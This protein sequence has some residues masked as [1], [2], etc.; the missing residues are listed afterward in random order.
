MDKPLKGPNPPFPVII[1]A[2]VGS[3]LHGISIGNDDRDE[4]GVCVEPPEYVIGQHIF[5]QYEYRSARERTGIRDAKSEKGDLDLVVYS[6]RKYLRL[7]CKGNPS[8]LLLLFVP[9]EKLTVQTSLGRELQELAPY[10]VSKRAGQH[11]LGYL[12]AQKQR[13]LRER[14]A[15]KVPN[16]QDGGK[17]YLAHILRLG[18][19]GVEFLS[20]GSMTLPMREEEREFVVAVRRGEVDSNEALT[21]AGLLEKEISDLLTESPIADEPD[22]ET[23]N[24]WLVETH[25]EAWKLRPPPVI[26]HGDH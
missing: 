11:F 5:D 20:Q 23:V 19:Q 17:K 1:Q 24:K 2:E 13:Y 7:A 25:Y 9:E 8:Q 26:I 3:T 21:K 18:Y 6:L 10:I 22:I 14:G 12:V 16:R 15:A 4:M